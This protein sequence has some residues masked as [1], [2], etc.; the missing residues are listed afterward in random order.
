[1]SALCPQPDLSCDACVETFLDA[2]PGAELFEHTYHNCG[3][4][5]LADTGEA[6]VCVGCGE[7]RDLGAEWRRAR[8]AAA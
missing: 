3:C 4:P 6:E 2:H 5:W 7:R 1:M 8:R